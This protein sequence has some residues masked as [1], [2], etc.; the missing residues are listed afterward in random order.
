M[1]DTMNLARARHDEQ[2][3]ADDPDNT[4]DGPELF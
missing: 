4:D 1:P 3:Y 2:R